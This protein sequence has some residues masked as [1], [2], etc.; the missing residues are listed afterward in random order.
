MVLFDDVVEVFDLTDL[1]ACLMFGIVAV[2]GRSVSTA[3]V[4]R[5]LLGLAVL[6]DRARQ[7]ATR[8]RPISASREQKV[9]RVTIAINGTVQILPFAADPDTP[10][11]SVRR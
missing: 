1:N 8:C 5:D 6:T 2:D 9:H 3:L 10:R 7:K 11:T 4:N